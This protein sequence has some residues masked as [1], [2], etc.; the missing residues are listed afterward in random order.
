LKPSDDCSVGKAS[1][2]EG[3]SLPGAAA[4]GAAGLP[5]WRGGARGAA[6]AAAGVGAA[7][8]GAGLPGWEQ[9]VG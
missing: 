5:H 2:R 6:G 8:A 4:A 3:S 7:A 1:A 9:R